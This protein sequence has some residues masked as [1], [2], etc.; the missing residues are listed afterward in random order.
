M[1][2]LGEGET[3]LSNFFWTLSLCFIGPQEPLGIPLNTSKLNC[4]GPSQTYQTIS[5]LKALNRHCSMTMCTSMHILCILSAHSC[6]PCQPLC[7]LF[8][9]CTRSL[10]AGIGSSLQTFPAHSDLSV[11][12]QFTLSRYLGLFWKPVLRS[13]QRQH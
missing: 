8:V 10:H 1:D 5:I 7:S 4:E 3:N 13:T 12:Y 9:R 11:G 2:K 6:I